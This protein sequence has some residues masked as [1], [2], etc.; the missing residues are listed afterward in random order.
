MMIVDA[1]RTH[2]Q[3]EPAS[4][5]DE[6]DSQEQKNLI[7]KLADS[8]AY[9]AEYDESILDGAIRKVLISV[10]SLQAD[11]FREQLSAP[12][13]S[14]TREVILNEYQECLKELRRY[15]DEENRNS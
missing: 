3:I 8:W 4:L 2:D 12:M 15:L 10:R 14:E 5:I 13:N 1:Y 6:A 7:S 9:S 11:A